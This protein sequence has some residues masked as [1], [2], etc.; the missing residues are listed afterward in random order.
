MARSPNNLQSSIG[1]NISCCW[2]RCTGMDRAEDGQGIVTTG[3]SARAEAVWSSRKSHQAIC[4]MC[5]PFIEPTGAKQFCF[6][7]RA[8]AIAVC[9]VEMQMLQTQGRRRESATQAACYDLPL[10]DVSC[11][12]VGDV[13]LA[14][15]WTCVFHGLEGCGVSDLTVPSESCAYGGCGCVCCGG[16]VLHLS[17]C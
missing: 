10:G 3:M 11:S 17:R 2:L 9:E 13:D 14:D 7:S 8:R 16:Q 4:G 1:F 15:V 6:F 12:H 5:E